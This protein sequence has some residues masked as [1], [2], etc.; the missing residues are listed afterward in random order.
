MF[1]SFPFILFKLEYIENFLQDNELSDYEDLM[2]KV[3]N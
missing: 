2:I 1:L 3:L